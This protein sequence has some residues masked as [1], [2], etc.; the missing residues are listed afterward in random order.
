M[1]KSYGS[2]ASNSLMTFDKSFTRAN[3]QPLDSTEV[4]YSLIDAKTY[5]ATDQ[6]YVGQV[7]S[8]VT[9]NGDNASPRYSSKSYV[10]ENENGDLRALFY[11]IATSSDDLATK[12][13]N[14]SV[15][16]WVVVISS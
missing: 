12:F 10:I 7:L 16:D 1:A 13:P 4:Y 11:E 8:V 6:A 9:D 2:V 15:G 5:A 14:A 3:G